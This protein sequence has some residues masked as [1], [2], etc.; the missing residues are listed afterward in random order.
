MHLRRPRLRRIP[1]G[2]SPNYSW[3]FGDGTITTPRGATFSSPDAA[4]GTY[5]VTL[6]VTDNNHGRAARA[7]PSPSPVSMLRRSLRTRPACAGLSC[8]FNASGSWDPDGTIVSYAWNFGDGTT[9]SGATASRTY[10]AGGDYTVTL[11]VT[12][13]GGATTTQAQSVT[14]VG[15]GCTWAISTARA[16][17]SRQ[18]LD[19]DRDDQVHDGSHATVAECRGQRLLDRWRH[20][21]VRYEQPAGSALVSRSGFRKRPAA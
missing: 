8:S 2:R 11:T 10:A 5:T 18:R 7:R 20:E 1:T 6:T 17:S 3:S 15:P 9:G 21:L 4:A 12:D 14:A 13:N 16:R 19:R